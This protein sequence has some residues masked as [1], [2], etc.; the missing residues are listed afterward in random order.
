MIVNKLIDQ[1]LSLVIRGTIFDI[2]TPRFNDVNQKIALEKWALQLIPI[3]FYGIS[4][5]LH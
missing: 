2:P 4:H 5:G 3:I 1:T